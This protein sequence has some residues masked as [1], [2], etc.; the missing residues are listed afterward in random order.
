VVGGLTYLVFPNKDDNYWQDR[1]LLIGGGLA[2]LG[3]LVGPGLGHVYAG[4]S[5]RLITGLLLRTV[6]LGLYFAGLGMQASWG[7]GDVGPTIAL[8][9]AVVA[10]SATYDIATVG[11]SVD[12]YNREH[13]LA[14]VNIYPCYFPSSEQAAVMI[15]VTW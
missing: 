3:V 10:F 6:P 8:P 5:S 7:D 14:R 11:R 12:K 1:A 2:G 9:L 15:S 4:N 13:G